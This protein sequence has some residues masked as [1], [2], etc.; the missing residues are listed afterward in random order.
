MNNDMGKP[1]MTQGKSLS[2]GQTLLSGV[3]GFPVSH[4]KSPRLHSYWLQRYSIDGA[5]LPLCVAPDDLDRAVRGLVAVGFRGANVTLPHKERVMA[6]CDDLDPLALRIGAVNT[7]VFQEGKIYGRNSDGFGFI[8][9][10]RQSVSFDFQGKRVA[11]L[12]AG[13]AARA[14]LVALQ[15]V[16]VSAITVVNRT[17]ERARA[18]VEDTKTIGGG[19]SVLPWADRNQMM[20]DCD[21]LVNT[22]SLGMTGQPPL[23]LDFSHLS[24]RT[25]VN[26]LVYA[27]LITPFL[28]QARARG[29]RIVDGLGMLLH[30]ARPGFEAWFGQRPEVTEDLRQVVGDSRSCLFWG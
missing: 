7:L 26:D 9:N 17:E 11:V 19:L 8:E 16:G 4:S 20:S 6:L 25:V 22:T 27:P 3:L 15:D 2:S 10:I 24:P 5:Y 29:A 12:G 1:P 28:A 14:V 13:G 30:Q 21:L 18:L 23:D